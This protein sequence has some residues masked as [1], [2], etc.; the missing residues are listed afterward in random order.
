MKTIIRK[1]LLYKTNVEYGDYCINHVLGCS[2]GCLYPCYAF[3]LK[4]R[5]GDVKDY[6]EWTEPKIVSNAM[7][8]LEKESK[9]YNNL[10]SKSVHLCFTTDPF[11]Y[12]QP[13]IISLTKNILA[14]LA[15]TE[16]QECTILTKGIYTI[17]GLPITDCF[18]YGITLVSLSEDFRKKYEPGAA[19]IKAR[20]EA[21]YHMFCTGAKTWVSMEPYPTPNIVEQ[22]I[23]EILDAIKFVDKIVF[24]RMNYNSLAAG[25]EEFYRE[26]AKKVSEFCSKNGIEC[27]IKRG[28]V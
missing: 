4:K 12:Q 5:T 10:K 9:K 2:H 22:D 26:Q 24:G 25:Y 23:D 1:S 8:L 21:L 15:N 20:I 17:T 27:Y 3:L 16:I 13:E 6:K 14:Y 11:M 19:P 7:E 18:K 28:T